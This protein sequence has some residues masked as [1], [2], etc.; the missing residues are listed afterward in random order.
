VLK[1]WL[2]HVKTNTLA[3][4]MF[5][6]QAILSGT[7]GTDSERRESVCIKAAKTEVVFDKSGFA[8]TTNSSSEAPLTITP[9]LSKDR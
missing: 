7:H 8:P 4:V 9:S 1:S 6:A 5:V 2:R 3:L